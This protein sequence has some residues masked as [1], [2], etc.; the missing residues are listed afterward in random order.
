MLDVA[1]A[2]GITVML[3]RSFEELAIPV[4]MVHD[5]ALRQA[6]A[7]GHTSTVQL[8]RKLAVSPS[9][10]QHVVEELREL[11]LI[12]VQGIDGEAAN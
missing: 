9:L 7:D 3:P 8:A 12:E 5:I 1:T 4:A 11:R 6:L 2:T 10:M